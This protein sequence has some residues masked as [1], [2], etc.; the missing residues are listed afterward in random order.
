MNEQIDPTAAINFIA[1]NAPKLAQAKA[2]RIYL[3]NFVKVVK[4]NQM[5]ESSSGSLGQKEVDAYAS[6]EYLEVI[7]GLKAAVEEETKI[8]YLIQA[9]NARI[10]VWKTMEYNK[11]AELR[12]L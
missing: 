10:D 5:N 12:N 8:F 2:D 4:S 11:R 6:K 1:T 3:E 9:A 7:K